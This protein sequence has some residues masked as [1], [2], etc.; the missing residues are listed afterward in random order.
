MKKLRKISKEYYLRQIM[1][2]WVILT[3]AIVMPVR[4]ALA[5]PNCTDDGGATVDQTTP[6][7]T[8]V[9]VNQKETL[10]KWGNLDTTG[11]ETV[12]FRDGA[13]VDT[14][15]FSDI[16]GGKTEFYGHLTG[17]EGMALY[18]RNR[19][20]FLF[21]PGSTVDVTQ[22]A[23]TSLNIDA[24]DLMNGLPF[25][26]IDG[27]GAGDI[28]N[29]GTI[30]AEAVALIGKNVINK[31]YIIAR[32]SVIMAAG[33]SVII[34]ENG[35]PVAVEVDM[36][37]QD[38][39]VFKVTNHEDG[40]GITV[41]GDTAQIVLA[42]G[43]I[44]SSALVMA[45]SFGGPEADAV[46]TIDID[47]AGDVIIT[48]QVIAEAEGDGENNA[49]AAV[50]ITGKNVTVK[51][52]GFICGDAMVK[53]YAHEGQQNTAD[54]T[55]TADGDGEDGNVSIE[56]EGLGVKGL[57]KAVAMNHIYYD[58]DT[59]DGLAKIIDGKTNTATVDITGTNVEI[60]GLSGEGEAMVMAIAKNEITVDHDYSD[61]SIE[62]TVQNLTNKAT[63]TIDATEDVSIV[64]G[65]TEIVVDDDDEKY[66]G[67][68]LVSAEAGNVLEIGEDSKN[69]DF[70]MDLTMA[71]LNN[72]AMV[73]IDAGDNIN[74]TADGEWRFF[75]LS[76][77]S[78]A[79]IQATAYNEIEFGSR[80]A[81]DITLNLTA[82]GLSNDADVQLTAANNNVE[83]AA[84]SGGET[85]IGV[86]A[87][88]EIEDDDDNTVNLTADNLLNDA[89]I[90]IDAGGDVLVSA[91]CEGDCSETEI[92]ALARNDMLKPG[93]PEPENIT[94]NAN[95]NISG[96][97]VEVT[98]V[99]C[100]EVLIEARAEYGTANNAGVDIVADVDIDI[101][102]DVEAYADT[103]AATANINFDAGG[104]VNIY[105]H[106][107]DTIKAW[108]ETDN[109]EGD[110]I[111]DVDITADGSVYID[112]DV[113]AKAI[114][115]FG[116]SEADIHI[117]TPKDGEDITV[118]SLGNVKAYALTYAEISELPAE[119]EEIPTVATANV[120]IQTCANV[121]LN[122]TVD[123]EAEVQGVG[124]CDKSAVFMYPLGN[125]EA[126][127]IVKAHEDVII[128]QVPELPDLPDKGGEIALLS[129]GPHYWSNGQIIAKAH[130]G[131]ENSADVTILAVSD[132]FVNNEIGRLCK[133]LGGG[134]EEIIAKTYN[135]EINNSHIGIVTRDSAPEAFVGGVMVDRGEGDI[136]VSGQIH[137]YA[138]GDDKNTAEVEMSAARDVIVNGGYAVW[139]S[140]GYVEVGPM[141]L[142]A[143]EGGQIMAQAQYGSINT[144]NVE[145]Y[146]GRDVT[147]HGA[148]LEYIEL[149]PNDDK[150]LTQGI[151]GGLY[152][153]GQIL[154]L[155]YG[156]QRPKRDL[157]ENTSSIG[158]YAKRDVTINDATVTGEPPVIN[159]VKANNNDGYPGGEIVAGAHGYVSRNDA[160]IVICAQEDV[161]IDGE[162]IAEAGTDQHP[163][164]EHYADIKISAG[165]EID[166]TGWIWAEADPCASVAE[167]SIVLRAP[168]GDNILIDI[169][170]EHFG[171][172][173]H[174][175]PDGDGLPDI[176]IG[177]FDCPDCDFDWIDWDWCVD[178]EDVPAL[179]APV[180]PL[181]Q[182]E[183]P[184]IEGCPQL[185]Q[186]AAMELGTTPETIQVGIGNAL[187]LNPTIQPCDACAALINAAAV[188]RDED[189][190]RMAAMVQAFNALAPA[191]APFTPEMATS[192]AMAFEGAAEGTLYASVT[193]YIDA[194]VQYVAVLD[195]D[196]G[197]PV[198]D[199][200]TF[201]MEK[202]G[203]PVIEN[204]NPN[205][206]AYIQVLLENIGG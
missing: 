158:I 32:E 169:T 19:A 155:T 166:G 77:E 202:H 91:E 123:A 63:V 108:A 135:G 30:S 189:G 59:D 172:R 18:F 104:N 58:T 105:A 115:E 14:K 94:N 165:G 23:V 51:G 146:A 96:T 81:D 4:I 119:G 195:I 28:T 205:I 137:S 159:G 62:L 25:T 102:G 92:S 193:E 13:L 168:V 106:E 48:D 152:D 72:T 124:V 204:D 177:P 183:I 34:T 194:F 44:W 162:V 89:L 56:A 175:N 199:S 70:I 95:V 154:A 47:A 138:Q 188:L 54:V 117:Y 191:D 196:L 45:Y 145:I 2:C 126:D 149:I 50:T 107:G 31:G 181:A 113:V 201:V 80:W 7:L 15:V 76:G 99:D 147:V 121:I 150:S 127:V 10:M 198:D 148:E 98:A 156:S 79:E 179:V 174:D 114:S 116:A 73:D 140:L 61:E 109:G 111:A 29:E 185:V 40:K 21:G 103:G 112:D 134:T 41:F 118:D 143:E 125:S 38:P 39:G 60:S 101:T 37:G 176:E 160:D 197:S 36:G 33:D 67:D 16:T 8:D 26:L 142:E 82:N 42:A 129:D 187:A 100:G 161:T 180:A 131:Y 83:I 22:L 9:L 132:V 170:E 178:C 27:L 74:V 12:A 128:N 184:R 64:G 3:M 24:D 141:L 78:E 167:A 153:G 66:Y 49:I 1:A 71:N 182:F 11:A 133:G 20:G 55:I 110:A 88:N 17:E 206:A 136:I 151:G 163:L 46:A 190:S 5:I 97:N 53:A 200:V 192:I 52:D 120:D 43:D 57:V 122:G 157:D 65:S 186:A 87:Y 93:E 68:S 69:D 130:G 75:I 203:T 164:N 6:N 171:I 85:S 144:A 90:D 35:S 139:G 84:L 86:D 173:D